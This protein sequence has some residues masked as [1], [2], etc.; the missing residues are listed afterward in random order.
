MRKILFIIMLTTMLVGCNKEKALTP[1]VENENV[2][3][4]TDMLNQ[5]TKI[6]NE[7]LSSIFDRYS[8]LSLYEFSEVDFSYEGTSSASDRWIYTPAIENN[9]DELLDLIEELFFKPIGDKAINAYMPRKLLLVSTLKNIETDIEEEQYF[10]DSYFGLTAFT[11]AGAN[12]DILGFDR[13]RKDAFKDDLISQYLIVAFR[14]GLIKI[15]GDFVITNYEDKT[16][17]KDNYNLLG[18]VED[19]GFGLNADFEA[20]I[21][22]IVSD[23]NEKL[24]SEGGRLTPAFDV[25]GIIQKKYDALIT[26]FNT[27]DIDIVSIANLDIE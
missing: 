24:H 9:V 22:M 2:P 5:G 17:S 1:T 25:N 16:V 23:S 14:K 13:A 10:K 26:F 18:Y 3:N 27:I 8:V 12:S 19:E 15:P 20:Y 7:K 11:V 21:R 4:V 6:H